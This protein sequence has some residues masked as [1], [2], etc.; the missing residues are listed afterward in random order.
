MQAKS[1]NETKS[2]LHRRP[3][4][5]RRT[6]II[7]RKIRPLTIQERRQIAIENECA[8]D[9]AVPRHNS[10]DCNRR[11][12]CAICSRN[13]TTY[14]CNDLK[15]KTSSA[16]TTS[17]GAKRITNGTS[18]YKTT[19]ATINGRNVR[20]LFDDGSG[21]SFISRR[22]AEL[23]RLKTD[24]VE[25]IY[26][27]TLSQSSPTVTGS[28]V[29]SLSIPIWNG[30]NERLKFRINDKLNKIADSIQS[31]MINT[32]IRQHMTSFHDERKNGRHI[33]LGRTTLTQIQSCIDSNF[34]EA[35][36]MITGSMKTNDR[37]STATSIT[38]GWKRT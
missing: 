19:M 25:P 38:N 27:E 13:H 21:T 7:K 37:R 3:R 28:K 12:K 14:L 31:A 36:K 15:P 18:L 20:V 22:L 35:K 11:L 6:V 2:L 23:W 9:K 10:K 17:N 29:V 4:Y 16:T 5:V 32:T 30:T 24:D 33:G 1:T 34:I 26:M 8:S